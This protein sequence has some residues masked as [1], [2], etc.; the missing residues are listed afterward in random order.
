MYYDTT[1]YKAPVPVV[2]DDRT[3]ALVNILPR[4]GKRLIARGVL[5]LPEVKRVLEN[6]WFVVS[7][8]ITPSYILE[9]LTGQGY[10]TANCTAGIVTEGRMASVLED[11]RLGPWVFKNGNL[12]ETPAPVV[13]DQFT[14]YDVSVKGANAVDPDGNIGVFAADKAGGT[15]GGIWPTITARGAH[16]VAPVSLERLIPSVIE[17]ARHCGNH[18]WDYTMGQSAGFMPVVNALV[19]TEVQA[20]ELLTGVTA[21]H[22]GSGGVAGSEGAVMLALEGEHDVVLKA[23]ELIEDIKGEPQFDPPR[24]VPYIREPETAPSR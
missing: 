24:L 22:V 19:V 1:P 13:L 11:D 10:D 7:R 17:A 14:A 12:D 21:V 2:R 8:G 3:H 23:F 20:I 9:E 18:L 5:A 16:W 15:V 4:E 6:G